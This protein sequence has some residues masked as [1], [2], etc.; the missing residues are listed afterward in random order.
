MKIE[1]FKDTDT[2]YISL[3]NKTSK[4]SLEIKEGMVIDLDEDNKI[5]GIE[6]E[7]A[8]ENIEIDKL[9]IL[10][11]PVLEKIAVA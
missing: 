1:Y 8:S 3:S 2:L 9:E 6:I 4:E 5:V 7:H 11:F 10:R